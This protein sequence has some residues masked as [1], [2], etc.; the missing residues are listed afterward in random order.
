MRA[1]IVLIRL[2]KVEDKPGTYKVYVLL[3]CPNLKIIA[4]RNETSQSAPM[5]CSTPNLNMK[6]E[7]WE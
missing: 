2:R 3:N 5:S 4:V 6:K 7:S 1:T